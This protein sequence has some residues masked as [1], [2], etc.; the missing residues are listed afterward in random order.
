MSTKTKAT[1]MGL[2]PA[3]VARMGL[4]VGDIIRRTAN[5]GAAQTRKEVIRRLTQ[6]RDKYTLHSAI[7][8]AFN[9]EIKWVRNMVARAGKRKGGLGRR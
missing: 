1:T 7:W 8:I 9:E 5:Y 6:E 3:V 2:D 4:L